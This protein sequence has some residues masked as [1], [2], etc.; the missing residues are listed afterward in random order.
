[1]SAP[2][3]PLFLERS[4]Y[5]RRRLADAARMLPLAGALLWAIPLLWGGQARSTT[6]LILVF[7]VWAAL[8]AL[9]ALLS[10]LLAPQRPAPDIPPDTAP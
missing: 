3:S 2:N 7:G 5:R 10:H 8:I 1:M 6:G 4:A 9:A